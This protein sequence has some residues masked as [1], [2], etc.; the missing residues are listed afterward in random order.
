MNPQDLARAPI[1]RL[2]NYRCRKCGGMLAQVYDQPAGKYVVVC[3]E[4]RCYP[5]AVCT[6]MSATIQALQGE[7]DA[8]EVMNEYPELFPEHVEIEKPKTLYPED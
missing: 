8:R 6:A 4:N 2:R 7:L 3:R 1:N 5:L